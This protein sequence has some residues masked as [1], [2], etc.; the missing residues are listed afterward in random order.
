MIS[1]RRTR[2]KRIFILSFWILYVRIQYKRNEKEKRHRRR[3]LLF[4][5]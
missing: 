1:R 3:Q 5:L 2:E 4:Y